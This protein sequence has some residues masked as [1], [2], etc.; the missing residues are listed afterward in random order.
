MSRGPT[1]LVC[2]FNLLQGIIPSLISLVTQL[3]I[4]KYIVPSQGIFVVS[5]V[6]LAVLFSFLSLHCR[7]KGYKE[8]SLP[9]L[10]LLSSLPTSYPTP[11]P[12][13]SVFLH[14]P[15]VALWPMIWSVLEIPCA[16]EKNPCQSDGISYRYLSTQLVCGILALK[17]LCWLWTTISVAILLLW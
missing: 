12:P 16:V 15:R 6:S 7:L 13:L 5:E 11:P 8:F 17:F 14:L 4:Q 1:R 2:P 10:L 9:P 3:F